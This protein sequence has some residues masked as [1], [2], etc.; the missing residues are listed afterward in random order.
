[1]NAELQRVSQNKWLFHSL[2]L[3]MLPSHCLH[4]ITVLDSKKFNSST[5]VLTISHYGH[6]PIFGQLDAA[7]VKYLFIHFFIQQTFIEHLFSSESYVRVSCKVANK[8]L[9]TVLVHRKYFI[10]PNIFIN[11]LEMH[12]WTDIWQVQKNPLKT[13]RV[14]V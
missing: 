12:R 6:M 2:A 13:T 9:Q 1:M 5:L 11:I 8:T 3:L 10:E 4:I 14:L 7:M